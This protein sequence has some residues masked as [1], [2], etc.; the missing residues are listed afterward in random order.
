MNVLR[1]FCFNIPCHYPHN[2]VL[3]IINCWFVKLVYDLLFSTLHLQMHMQILLSFFS[4]P[5]IGIA[6]SNLKTILK[7]V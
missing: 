7:E 6:D 5:L 3:L 1:V 2:N 4:K